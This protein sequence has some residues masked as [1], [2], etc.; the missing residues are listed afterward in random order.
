MLALSTIILTIVKSDL[1]SLESGSV[2]YFYDILT[3]VEMIS[4]LSKNLVTKS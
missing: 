4:S 1:L 3:K 2:A